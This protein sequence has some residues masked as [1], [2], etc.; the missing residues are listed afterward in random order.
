MMQSSMAGPGKPVETRW[1]DGHSMCQTTGNRWRPHGNPRRVLQQHI[2]ASRPPVD[3]G[4]PWFAWAR[5][6]RKA[7]LEQ[8]A[9]VRSG[10]RGNASQAMPRL[11]VGAEGSDVALRARAGRHI[12][13]SAPGAAPALTLQARCKP[14]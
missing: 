1:S 7:A 4:M 12:A 13:R 6:R 5:G 11:R 2:R 14:A 3:G 9:S 8:R 10:Q